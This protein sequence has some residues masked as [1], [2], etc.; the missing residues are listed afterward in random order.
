MLSSVEA[1]WTGLCA[2]PFDKLRVTS[3]LYL[4][5]HAEFVSA[6]HWQVPVA[7]WLTFPVGCRNEFGMT[8]FCI[9]F[10]LQKI[11]YFKNINFING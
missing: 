1:W 4:I 6:S 8:R 11:L 5:C 2:R 3:Q 10:P 9:L 7:R